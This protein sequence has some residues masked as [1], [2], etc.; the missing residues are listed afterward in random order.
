RNLGM[1]GAARAVAQACA[2]N[3]LALAGPCHRVVRTDGALSGYRWGVGCK[4]LL[5]ER[6][7]EAGTAA[8]RA[9]AQPTKQPREK[10]KSMPSGT[11]TSYPLVKPIQRPRKIT[12]VQIRMDSAPASRAAVGVGALRSQAGTPRKVTNWNTSM[13]MP[14]SRMASIFRRKAMLNQ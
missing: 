7:R 14:A 6:E 5:L 13:L 2:A 12:L 8:G 3:P 1:P 10:S 9:T 4:R 11:G